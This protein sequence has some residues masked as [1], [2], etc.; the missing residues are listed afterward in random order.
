MSDRPIFFRLHEERPRL[1]LA[2]VSETKLT[3][4]LCGIFL[5]PISGSGGTFRGAQRSWT[6]NSTVR[7]N[8]RPR[9]KRVSRDPR[10]GC[11]CRRFR[12]AAGGEQLPT[13]FAYGRSLL[14]DFV[15]HRKYSRGQPPRVQVSR[16]RLP[17]VGAVWVGKSL[18]RPRIRPDTTLQALTRAPSVSATRTHGP[19]TVPHT[20]ARTRTFHAQAHS[21]AAANAP[22][23]RAHLEKAP[24]RLRSTTSAS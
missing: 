9:N 10:S 13:A 24:F 19:A 1:F 21:S 7:A 6:A 23:R 5:A 17:P 15:I 4:S 11:G 20:R 18:A 12:R 2:L 3:G 16:V 14:F 8:L 22:P